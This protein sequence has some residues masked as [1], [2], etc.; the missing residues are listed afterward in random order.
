MRTAALNDV[1][2]QLVVWGI[3]TNINAQHLMEDPVLMPRQCP[4]ILGR[5][6]DAAFQL[7]PIPS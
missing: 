3:W 4:K 6:S 7:H 2:V 5:L 1:E